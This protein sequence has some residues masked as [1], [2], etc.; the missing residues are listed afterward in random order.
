MIRKRKNS[1]FNNYRNNNPLDKNNEYLEEFS[2]EMFNQGYSKISDNRFKNEFD[3]V[4]HNHSV[5]NK[6]TWKIK[7][8]R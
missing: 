1:V 8:E 3:N 4:D 5:E 2:E 6:E 7:G